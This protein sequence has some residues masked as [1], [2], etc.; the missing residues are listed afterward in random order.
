[1]GLLNV[2]LVELKLSSVL[3]GVLMPGR[4]GY[5]DWQKTYETLAEMVVPRSTK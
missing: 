4:T 3:M 1:M 5:A 2:W